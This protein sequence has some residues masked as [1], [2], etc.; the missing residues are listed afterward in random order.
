VDLSLHKL[1]MM[2]RKHLKQVALSGWSNASP[3]LL[4]DVNMS[5]ELRN[6]FAWA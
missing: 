6:S 2:V 3:E 5:G 1:A 4:T